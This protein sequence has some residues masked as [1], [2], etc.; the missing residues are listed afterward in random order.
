MPSGMN[1]APP[2]AG[3]LARVNH[4][5]AVSSCKGGV[6]KSTVAV[7][8]AYAMAGQGLRVGIFDADVYGPS[9]PTMVHPDKGVDLYKD[10]E[11]IVPLEAFG[12]KLMSFGW[13]PGGGGAAIMRGPRV[14]GVVSQLLTETDW[15]E[16]DVLVIDYPPGTGDIQLT[17]GQSLKM[18]GAVVVTTPQKLALVDVEK[19]IEMFG[20]LEVPTLGIVENM[21]YFQCGDC[22]TR[23]RLFGEG[24]S[25][26][27]AERFGIERRFELPLDPALSERGDAGRPLVLD[28][29]GHPFFA[30]A[31]E[32]YAALEEQ[33]SA[34]NAAPQLSYDVGGNMLLTLAD[35]SECEFTPAALRRACGCAH[36]VDENTGAQ[37][38]EPSSVNEDIYPTKIQPMGNYAIAVEWSEA[39]GKCQ[40]SI[41][42]T[43]RLLE[44]FA[45]K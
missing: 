32:V 2:R 9:L 4:V 17:L 5:L 31:S 13:V 25:A 30:I 43:A 41:F 22:G 12:V 34:A 19:G 20:K 38:L 23:T 29:P 45:G 37:L 26:A 1:T 44:D 21:S 14:S 6:G 8:L 7:N 18:S 3:G 24:A 40:R 15:G 39:N 10:G 28:T 33:A 16:L 42:P 36:C 11:F 35:G 27:L